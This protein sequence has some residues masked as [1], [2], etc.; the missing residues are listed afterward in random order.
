MGE[1]DRKSFINRQHPVNFTHM[2]LCDTYSVSVKLKLEP[3]K[4][5]PL[6]SMPAATSLK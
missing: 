3:I 5:K 6:H 4:K 1:R 2:M